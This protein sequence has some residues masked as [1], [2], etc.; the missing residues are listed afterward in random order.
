MCEKL[1]TFAPFRSATKICTFARTLITF[2]PPPHNHSTNSHSHTS[3][4]QYT[5]MDFKYMNQRSKEEIL[6]REKARIVGINK[7][8]AIHQSYK[9]SPHY[10]LT[11][12]SKDRSNPVHYLSGPARQL[13]YVSANVNGTVEIIA[14]PNQHSPQ[15]SSNNEQQLQLLNNP[16]TQPSMLKLSLKQKQLSIINKI[17][18]K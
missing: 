6:K 15:D 1:S 5:K 8:K 12:P 11:K 2:T 4:G 7:T 10:S 16:Y 14:P 3:T 13:P 9:N 17:L 18:S